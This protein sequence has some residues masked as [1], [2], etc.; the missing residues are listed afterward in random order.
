MFL[1]TLALVKISKA[2]LSFRK[3]R[4]V[5][6]YQ[7]KLISKRDVQQDEFLR[8]RIPAKTIFSKRKLAERTK[9]LEPLKF[10]LKD[11]TENHNELVA[12]GGVEELPFFVQRTKSHNLPVYEDYRQQRLLKYTL[13]KRVTGNVEELMT[14][15]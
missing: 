7:K 5:E 6:E 11:L 4:P 10:K 13:V 12:L 3:M 14:E 1:N 8:E 2:A 9:S 15:L